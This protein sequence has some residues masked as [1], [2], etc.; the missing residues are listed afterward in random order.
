A[1]IRG[2]KHEKP[3]RHPFVHITGKDLDRRCLRARNRMSLVDPLADKDIQAFVLGTR[4]GWLLWNLMSVAGGHSDF[5]FC[6]VCEG[7]N[8]DHDC[9]RVPAAL[10]PGGRSSAAPHRGRPGPAVLRPARSSPR[11]RS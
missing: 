3:T 4:Y 2:V 10:R 5:S 6:F 8:C 9:I 1:A 7:T 11:P